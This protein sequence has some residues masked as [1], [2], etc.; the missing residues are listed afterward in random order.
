MDWIGEQARWWDGGLDAVSRSAGSESE[1]S[2]DLMA[3][4]EAEASVLLES[5][6]EDLDDD[7][8]VVGRKHG[9]TET[10]L[11]GHRVFDKM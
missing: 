10:G 3:G 6:Q 11:T 8:K 9:D 1:E 2:F 4:A 5:L 7:E